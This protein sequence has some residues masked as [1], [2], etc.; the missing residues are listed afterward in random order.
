MGFD[1]ILSAFQPPSGYLA[2]FASIRLSCIWCHPCPFPCCPLYGRQVWGSVSCSHIP[3]CLWVRVCWLKVH[4]GHLK[5][6]REVSVSLGRCEQMLG[7]MVDIWFAVACSYLLRITCFGV[8]DS[9]D[10]CQQ[11]STFLGCLPSWFHGPTIACVSLPQ[12]FQ[13]LC[14]PLSPFSLGYR[15]ASPPLRALTSE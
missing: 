6:R 8:A 3:V 7:H 14:K 11:L 4:A 1:G 5:D 13:S 9:W 12:P 10:Y 2:L 15:S